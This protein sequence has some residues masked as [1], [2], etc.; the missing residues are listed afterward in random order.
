MEQSIEDAI[1][2]LIKRINEQYAKSRES[3]LVITKLEEA[4]LWFSKIP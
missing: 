2:E 4:A 1:I 3:S